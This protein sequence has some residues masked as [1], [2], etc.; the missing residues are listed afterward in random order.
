MKSTEVMIFCVVTLFLMS[1]CLSI[2][3]FSSVINTEQPGC[4]I[5]HRPR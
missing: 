1:V 3:V 4:S 2:F 5:E